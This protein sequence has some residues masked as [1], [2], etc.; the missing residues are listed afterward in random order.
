VPSVIIPQEHNILINP[1]HPLFS[2]VK[3]KKAEKFMFDA[4][5]FKTSS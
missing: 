4:R 5:L 2:K 1:M 3:I